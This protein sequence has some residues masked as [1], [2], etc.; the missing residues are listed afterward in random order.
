MTRLDLHAKLEEILGS[1]LVY[2]QPPETLK[3]QYPCI[4]YNRDEGNMR[5]ADNNPYHF[6]FGYNVTVIDRNPDSPIVD[7][8]TTLP[9][10]RFD[11]H[12]TANN[13]NHDVFTVYI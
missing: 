2:F 8:M 9:K 11:R 4:V 12:F 3:M 7:R 1:D 5:H 10:C 6:E 13:F